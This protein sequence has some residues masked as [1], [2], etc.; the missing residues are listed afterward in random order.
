MK[1]SIFDLVS[2]LDIKQE[3]V[4][5]TFNNQNVKVKSY[6]PFEDKRRLIQFVI[7]QNRRNKNTG[8]LSRYDIDKKLDIALVNYY[9]DYKFDNIADSDAINEAY[10]ILETQGFFQN[11]VNT[12]PK[13]EYDYITEMLQYEIDNDNKF[14]LTMAGSIDDLISKFGDGLGNLEQAM[15]ELENFDENKF[16]H[17][18]DLAQRLGIKSN[19]IAFEQKDD[20][21]DK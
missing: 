1:N 2:N 20:K 15:K 21:T 12:I 14:K 8:M 4:T 6:I 17:V 5:I 3:E 13:K 7:N 11:L 16:K 19:V 9:T 18:S 10:D